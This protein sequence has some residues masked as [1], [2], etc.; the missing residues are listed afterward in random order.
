MS[1]FYLSIGTSLSFESLFTGTREPY[2]LERVIPNKVDIGHYDEMWINLFTL[3]RNIVGSVPTVEVPRLL[4]GDIAYVLSEEVE[5]IQELLKEHSGGRVPAVFYTSSY[6]GL[7]RLYKHAIIRGDN[8]E[9]QRLMTDLLGQTLTIFYKSHQL[10]KTYKH[11]K[12]H[13]KDE[14]QS[15]KKVL[16]LSHYAFDLL[17]HKAFD[18]MDL[19]ESHTGILK[20]RAKWHTKYMDGK[21]LNRLPFNQLFLQVFGDSQTFRPMDKQ[22]REDIL[23]IAEASNWNPLTTDERIRFTLQNLKNPFFKTIIKD[24]W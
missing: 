23:E 8:T 2:D 18:K 7:E 14:G 11:F 17:S 20:E 22:L 15:R 24:M 12:V 16:L 5:T 13:L 19:L 4:P 6:E 3:F 1:A 10:G 9:K 21:N